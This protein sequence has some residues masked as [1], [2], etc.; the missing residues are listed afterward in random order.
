MRGKAGKGKEAGVEKKGRNLR[1]KK[2]ESLRGARPCAGSAV[3]V[4]SDV[5]LLVHYRAKLWS[6]STHAGAHVL[7]QPCLVKNTLVH[8]LSAGLKA[9]TTRFTQNALSVCREACGGHGEWRHPPNEFIVVH[10]KKKCAVATFETDGGG[11]T[12]LQQVSGV[13]P[14]VVVILNRVGAVS[15]CV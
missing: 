6:R 3:Q 2:G 14:C 10:R 12:V 8:A 5:C 1:F 9:Y 7:M 15:V 4:N 11:D 13:I